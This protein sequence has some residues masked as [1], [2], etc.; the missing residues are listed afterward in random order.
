MGQF[1]TLSD[2]TTTINKETGE[3]VEKR[4][5]KTVKAGRTPPFVMIFLK[6]LAKM[7][8]L[9]TAEY[10]VLMGLLQN[11]DNKNVISVTKG[12]KDKIAEEMEINPNSMNTLIGNLKKKKVILPES[13]GRFLVNPYFFGRGEWNDISEL[14]QTIKYDFK[15]GTKTTKVESK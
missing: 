1:I 9:T 7:E 10:K 3:I 14:R 6:D 11:V 2:S 8:N 13:K 12:L 15:N 4:R 5:E